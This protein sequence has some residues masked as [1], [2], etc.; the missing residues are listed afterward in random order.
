MKRFETFDIDSAVAKFRDL[1]P[2]ASERSISVFKGKA[3]RHLLKDYSG[4]RG[5]SLVGLGDSD[6]DSSI[7]IWHDNEDVEI[8]YCVTAYT[9]K[10]AE[11]FDSDE[12]LGY[13]G[14]IRNAHRI[15]ECKEQIKSD[16]IS[17]L[18]SKSCEE[19]VR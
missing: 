18:G 1:R 4:S 3:S 16:N 11:C 10:D 8:M 6:C 19:S 13:N 2:D 14:F 17:K 12:A 5:L 15:S 7:V 9:G